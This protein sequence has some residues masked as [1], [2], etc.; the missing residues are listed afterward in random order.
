MAEGKLN[1][2][3][4]NNAA[5]ALGDSLGV[6]ENLTAEERRNAALV[7][8]IQSGIIQNFEVAYDQCWKMMKRWL[9][10]NIGRET[11]N[12]ITRKDL[13]R[14]AGKSG[15]ISD[16]EK[17]FKFHFA[18]ND[19]S[20]NYDSTLVVETIKIASDFFAEMRTLR[21]FFSEHA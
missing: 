13:F 19:A 9:D 4:L 21:Q 17:W 20:H 1:F 2:E 14:A 3:K 10:V 18:R 12:I 5:V 16:A 15:M 11:L 6:L 8:T 7:R